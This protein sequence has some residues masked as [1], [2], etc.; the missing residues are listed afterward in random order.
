LVSEALRLLETH[1]DVREAKLAL[2][3]ADIQKGLISGPSS[4]S[5]ADDLKREARA[6]RASRAV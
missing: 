5:S 4:V 2:L 6:R 3:R 1:D